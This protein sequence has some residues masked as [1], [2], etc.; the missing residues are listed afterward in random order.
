VQLHH[1]T[2]FVR[3][4]ERS[5]RF[6]RD[7]LGLDVLVDRDFDGDWAALLGVDSKRLRAIIL[8][9]PTA[10]HV[11]QVELVTFAEPLAS[12]PA[13]GVPATATVMLS[14]QVDLR[15]VLPT[16]ERLGAAEHGRTTLS[17]GN[18]VATVRDPDGIMVELIDTGS[19]TVTEA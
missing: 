11:G 9:D 10:P 13:P 19:R 3:D 16:L 7:G 2:L 8:G 6:Y 12:G 4:A 1:A 15:T 18:A 5:T 14:F 17:N